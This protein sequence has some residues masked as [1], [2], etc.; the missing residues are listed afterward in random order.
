MVIA[1]DGSLQLHDVS[2]GAGRRRK[3]PR[4]AGAM[5][6]TTRIVPPQAGQVDG[7]DAVSVVFVTRDKLRN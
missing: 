1:G 3:E 5:I 2:C 7:S 6:S 4:R